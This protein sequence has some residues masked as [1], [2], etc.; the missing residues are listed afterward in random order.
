MG[1]AAGRA[2]RFNVE[3]LLQSFETVPQPFAAPK[4]DGRDDNM[5]V[6]DEIGREELSHGGW[7]T[8]NAD[9]EVA[10]CFSGGS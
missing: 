3:A 10:R 1:N 7:A 4:D 6:V 5:H 9:I 8:A 2:Y